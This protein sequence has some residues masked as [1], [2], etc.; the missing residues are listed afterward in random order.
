MNPH[1]LIPLSE[2]F[3]LGLGLIVGIGPQNAFVLQQ[4]LK[5]QFILMIALLTSLIDVALISLGASGAGRLF[6]SVPLLGQLAAWAGAV[7]LLAYGWRSFK[8]A[9]RLAPLFSFTPQVKLGRRAVVTGILAVSFLNPSTYLDTV[10]VIGGNAARYESSLRVFFTVGATFASIFWFFTLTFGAARFSGFLSA[11]G[12][13]RIVD[14]LGG[15][16]MWA[17]AV[18]LVLHAAGY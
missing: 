11:P 10:L 17:I 18:R 7:F 15:V 14:G 16:I 5:R 3:L 13:L 9:F 12:S 2:G 6:A 8:A 4:S 1:L